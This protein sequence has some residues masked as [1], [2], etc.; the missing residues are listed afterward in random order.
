MADETI[1]T[2]KEINEEIYTTLK[3][4]MEQGKDAE[5]RKRKD[6]T[7]DIFELDRKK[8]RPSGCRKENE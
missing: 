1:G 4:V 8:C 6:G 3:N 2:F 7:Y 5:I